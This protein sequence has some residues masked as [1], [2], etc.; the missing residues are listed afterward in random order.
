MQISISEGALA[1]TQAA[2]RYYINEGAPQAAESFLE[3]LEHTID[4]LR[5]FP[6][7]GAETYPGT[8]SLPLNGFPFSLI[9]HLTG[10]TLRIIAVAHHRRRPEY[11][12]RRD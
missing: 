11:W 6:E 7:I 8:R 4:I 9:Y 1:E 2:A 10:E 3:Q 12:Q 5:Q